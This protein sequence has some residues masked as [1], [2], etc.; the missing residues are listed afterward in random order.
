MASSQ[1]KLNLRNL[2]SFSSSRMF[3]RFT[4]RTAILSKKNSFLGSNLQISFFQFKSPQSE[5]GDPLQDLHSS[6]QK[7]FSSAVLGWPSRLFLEPPKPASEVL[8]KW[9]SQPKR[10]KETFG[11]PEFSRP[12]FELTPPKK[13]SF[14]SWNEWIQKYAKQTNSPW[15]LLGRPHLH[16]IPTISMFDFLEFLWLFHVWMGGQRTFALRVIQV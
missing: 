1:E 16:Q 2:N 10:S 11:N 5:S 9:Y 4:L 6:F 15:S 7:Q 13:E 3:V 8:P 12:F 14:V